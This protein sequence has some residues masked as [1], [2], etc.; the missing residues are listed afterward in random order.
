VVLYLKIII[1][2]YRQAIDSLWNNKLRTFLSLLGISIGI[3][4]IIAVKSAVDSLQNNIVDGFKELGNDVIYVDKQ[5]WN[6]DPNQNWWKYINRPNPSFK[7][8]EAIEKR[9]KRIDKAAFVIFSG[10]RIAKYKNNSISNAFIMGATFDYAS[11]QN[12]NIE[13]GRGFNQTEYNSASNKI[14][15]GYKVSD[16]LFGNIDPVGRE[17]KLYGQTFQVIG[18][19][20]SEGENMFN[21]INFDDVLYMCYPTITKFVNTNDDSNVGRMLLVKAKEG[22]DKEDV[23]GELIGIMRANR[24]IKPRL[25]NN[26][27]LNELTMLTDLLDNVFGVLNLAG[28][29]IGIF[30][31]IVGM[32]SVANIM[33]VSVKERTS[34]I[35]IKKALGAQKFVI[36]LEFLIESVIL[37]IIGGTVG[38]L[39]VFVILKAVTAISKF[40]MGLSIVNI[41]IGVGVS[42][43][44]GIIAGVIP[45]VKASK[46]DPVEAIRS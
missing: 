38:L 33:F 30:A 8:Y 19:L 35:G 25:E 45:A 31:L 39:L 15:L 23:K 37:C 34:I 4:C 46:M 40:E 27:A 36:L 11:I 3:F 32:F 21:F 2:S 14:I 44:V 41:I 5:P 6:E 9:G 42:V 26:F 7:D 18:K 43:I 22:Q 29:M 28:F 16:A 24:K 12:L 13:F 20:K 1:E 10:G 17:I